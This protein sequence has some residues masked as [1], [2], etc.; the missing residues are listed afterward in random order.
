MDKKMCRGKKG[1]SPL[2]AVVLLIAITL[3]IGGFMSIW[4]Q[5][6]TKMQTEQALAG[7][8]PECQRV[9]L[10]INNATYNNDTNVLHFDVKNTGTAN[11]KINKIQVIYDNDTIVFAAMNVTDARA[12][13]ITPISF[14]NTTDYD[15]K[16]EYGNLSQAIRKVNIVTECPLNLEILK[17]D[18]S[19][20]V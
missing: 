6:I 2:I 10:T 4:T 12:Q 7:A 11:T 17:T 15:G 20:V 13:L 19:G 5:Q 1:V 14:Y 18:I 3:A 9:F 16:I 8:R